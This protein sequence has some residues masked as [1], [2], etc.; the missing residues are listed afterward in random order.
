MCLTTITPL[1]SSAGMRIMRTLFERH[2]LPAIRQYS[3][4]QSKS[5][6]S[7]FC[8]TTPTVTSAG[9][10]AFANNANN[11]LGHLLSRKLTNDTKIV[12]LLSS[13]SNRHPA[14]MRRPPAL[15][16]GSRRGGPSTHITFQIQKKKKEMIETIIQRQPF[17]LSKTSIQV[18]FNQNSKIQ[19]N[20]N[21]NHII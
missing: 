4:K 11:V 20:E 3:L 13:F 15:R 5:T 12:F 21:T 1:D 6:P 16:Q 8:C 2:F 17:T 10:A 9:F 7:L 14:R 19:M 18:Q